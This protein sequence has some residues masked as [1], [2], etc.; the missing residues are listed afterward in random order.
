MP[1][2][3]L[4]PGAAD[5]HPPIDAHLGQGV[6]DGE[7]LG[8]LYDSFGRTLRAVYANRTGVVI[9]RTESPLVNR[10]DAIVHLAE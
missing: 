8:S 1:G 4:G 6:T 9:G 10:G 2:Q 3:G 5:R 7:R